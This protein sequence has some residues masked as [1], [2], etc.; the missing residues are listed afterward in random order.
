MYVYTHWVTV[1][2]CIICVCSYGD[3]CTIHVVMAMHARVYM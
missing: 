3:V 1:E 2:M